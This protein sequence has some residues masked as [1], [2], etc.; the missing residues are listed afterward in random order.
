[1]L[2]RTA[3]APSFEGAGRALAA[4]GTALVH[5][6]VGSAWTE[7]P[8]EKFSALAVLYLILRYRKFLAICA[9]MGLA[10]GLILTAM[11]PALYQATSRMEVQPA[12]A[13][14]VEDLQVSRERDADR[15]AMTARERILSG[16]MARRVAADMNLANNNEFLAEGSSNPLRGIFS[17][18]LA[19]DRAS[20]VAKLPA[21]AR[22]ELAANRL[23]GSLIV[24]PSPGTNIL[25]ITVRDESP[26]LAAK[27]ADQYI[28]S[29][30][31][32][33][34]D[35]TVEVSATTQK[36]IHEQVIAVKARLET[37]EQNL[38]DYAREQN[39]R[40]D[41]NNNSLLQT[42]ISSINTALQEAQRKRIEQ[43]HYVV[44]INEGRAAELPQVLENKGIESLRDRISDL[45][46]Q[47]QS[48]L[49]TM[50]PTMPE[51]QQLQARIKEQQRQIADAVKIISESLKMTFSENMARE[52]ALQ[53]RLDQLQVDSATF[54]DKN[55]KYTILK[56]EVDSYRSQYQS[57]ISKLN[58]VDISS[59]IRSPSAMVADAA[60]VPGVPVSP[61]LLLNVIGAFVLSLIIAA[62]IVYLTELLNNSFARPDQIENSLHIPLLGI[63]PKI[64][65]D[66]RASALDARSPLNE[67]YRSL[68]TAIQ[69]SGQDGLLQVL[70]VTSTEPSEGKST[71][72][73]RLASEFAALGLRVLV[74]DADMRKPSLHRYFGGDHSVGLS[75]L[76]TSTGLPEQVDQVL[77]KT[78]VEGLSF[79]SSGPM[80]PSP[81]DLLSSARM[82]MI[83][84][85]CKRNFDITIIDCPPVIGLADAPI[86][87]RISD[88]TVMV[89]GAR[90]V[91]R[92][93]ALN[94]T[95]R[96]RATGGVLLGGA[97]TKFTV[98]RFDY[99]YEYRYVYSNAYY[100][101]GGTTDQLEDKRDG[102]KGWLDR[103]GVGLRVRRVRG[104]VRK[105]LRRYQ[106]VQ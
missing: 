4:P 65:A 99:N 57:L 58:E 23:K 96:L 72:S 25:E 47:Y 56:R 13:K 90:G 39:L 102:K 67:A 62:L 33:R 1:M 63:I 17:R 10:A 8:E 30:I 29:Y 26:A 28:R 34:V 68:R 94:A 22:E 103:S 76:L 105:Y 37:A 85:D 31:D 84:A 55:I 38:A 19:S 7:T 35:S 91:T 52:R 11:M 73:W 44:V 79:I 80:P 3:I 100:Q 69:F 87:A 49:A 61:N 21:R 60:A 50:K 15:A 88:G 92:K 6:S 59:E 18:F 86:I 42:D 9:A 53:Q 5:A 24:K 36:F 43:Q 16:I 81:A 78:D 106:Q 54:T 48:G 89:V 98:D 101:Y 41:V 12:T 64:E 83:I 104:A 51:M 97:L 20:K 46:G 66:I 77:H 74:I 45:K 27:I 75:N 2:D 82:G 95:K 14:V 32:H 93:A 71:T 40:L 70:S